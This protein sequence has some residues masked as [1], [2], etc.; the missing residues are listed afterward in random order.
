M[1]SGKTSTHN[2]NGTLHEE[3]LVE[4]AAILLH[5]LVGIHW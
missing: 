3:I 4:D 5:G 1:N 2:S